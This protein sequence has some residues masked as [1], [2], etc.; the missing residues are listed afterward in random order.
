M[1]YNENDFS[2]QVLFSKKIK[3]ITNH[4]NIKKEKGGGKDK[5]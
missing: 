4:E 1:K 3:Y 5:Y 2:K